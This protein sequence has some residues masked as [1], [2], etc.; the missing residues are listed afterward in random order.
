MDKKSIIGLVLIFLVFV[1]Y[2]FWIRPSDEEIAERRRA[3]SIAYAEYLR[4]DSI[5]RAAD[6]QKHIED[7]LMSL[8]SDSTWVDSTGALQASKRLNLGQ[9]AVN[10]GNPLLNVTVK[11]DLISAEL[12]SLGASVQ[13]VILDDYTTFDSTP[14]QVITPANDNFDLVFVDSKSDIV[15]TSKIPFAI[16]ANGKPLTEDAEL[17]VGEGDSLVLS[18]RALVSAADS[19][20]TDINSYLEFRYVFRH[21][22][23]EVDF[24]VNFHNI[25]DY[26][27]VSPNM[28][29]TWNNRFNRQEQFDRSQKGRNANRNKD[30]ERFYT[31]LYYK[32]I[33]DNA[34]WLR[35]G[36][37]DE[38]Q[39]TTPI[40]WVAYK[41]QFFCAILMGE[42]V[43]RN[44]QQLK[45]S[46]DKSNESDN[47]L[48]DMSSSMGIDYDATQND[49]SLDMAFYFGPNKYRELRDMP[50]FGLGLL[51]HTVGQPF[52]H[53]S[54]LQLPREFRLELWHY[55]HCAYVAPQDLHFATHMEQL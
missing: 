13:S 47:Y 51:P 39:I 21:A 34:D 23:Y 48:C 37:D 30:S 45:V 36:R 1:G 28:S 41:Q 40:E 4:N 53:Y 49:Y 42:N 14:L 24:D 12:Q 10:S 6:R 18:F 8:S 50:A 33:N 52:R 27:N 9:F 55:H 29:L 19:L 22:S 26:V 25:R 17:T 38:K 31:T 54:G 43:F 2:M 35:D 20:P 32:N 3:D 44:A 7:S 15:N 11:N 5:Q 16:F 46:T